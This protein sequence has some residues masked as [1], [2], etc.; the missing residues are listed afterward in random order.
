MTYQPPFNPYPY[1]SSS[2]WPAW[3]AGTTASAYMAVDPVTQQR[4]WFYVF[5]G[6][7]GATGAP[8]PTGPPGGNTGSPGPTGPPGD[9]GPQGITGPPGDTGPQGIT[10]PPGDTGAPGPQGITGPPGDTGAPGP[11]GITGPPGP[12]GPT[13]APGDTGAPGPTGITAGPIG[14]PGVTGPPGD[15]G[16]QGPTGHTGP[17]G[18]RGETGAPG[19]GGTAIGVFAGVYNSQIGLSDGGI[20]PYINPEIGGASGITSESAWTS[21]AGGF[22]GATFT[23]GPGEAGKYLTSFSTRL[24]G[25]QMG[26]TAPTPSEPLIFSWICVSSAPGST[27]SR[28]DQWHTS[29]DSVQNITHTAFFNAHEGDRIYLEFDWRVPGGNAWEFAFLDETTQ[30]TIVRLGT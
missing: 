10:G 2:P 28:I 26:I 3:P 8:G 11:Q 5:Q 23:I 27:G 15:T 22:S 21:R 16:P 19:A 7:T 12:Q 1:S 25:A 29:P 30:F 6:P 9:T 4:K 14:P 20:Q 13:G 17:T 18:E 24:T